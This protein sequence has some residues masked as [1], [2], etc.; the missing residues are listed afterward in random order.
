M[1]KQGG[2]EGIARVHVT[3][4]NAP[5]TRSH[6]ENVCVAG[7]CL[8]GVGGQ[9]RRPATVKKFNPQLSPECAKRS[10]RSPR[11]LCCLFCGSGGTVFGGLSFAV[12]GF[13]VPVALPSSEKKKKNVLKITKIRIHER[14]RRTLYLLTRSSVPSAHTVAYTH[15]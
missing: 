6:Q 4:K 13:G 14:T 2:Y 7:E 12:V 8:Q 9:L 3:G 5:R 10:P 11:F 15:P 1:A